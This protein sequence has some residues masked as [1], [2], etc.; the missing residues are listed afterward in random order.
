MKA[1]SPLQSLGIRARVL[2]LAVLPLT[3]V[4]VLLG[5][6]LAS[7]RLD[8]AHKGLLERGEMIARN[9]ALA[10]EFALI[11]HNAALLEETLARVASQP[12]VSWVAV[13][14]HQRET[15]AGH[16]S[17][18]APG[19]ILELVAAV[20]RGEALPQN[21]HAQ[22]IEVA[23]PPLTDFSAEYLPAGPGG[24]GLAN[25]HLGFA[26]VGMDA[27]EMD[28]RRA[29]IIRNSALVTFTGLISSIVLALV[30]GNSIAHPLLGLLA[31]VRALQAG[32]LS[33]RA[34]LSAGGEIGTLVEGVNRM[35]DHLEQ[36]QRDMQLRVEQATQALRH[37]VTEL[38]QRNRELD[39]ARDAA[40]R[41]GRDRTE[42]LA[43]MSHEIRTPLNAILGFA[44]LLTSDDRGGANS[45]HLRTI[46]TAAEQLLHVIDDIL[47]FI[48]L[49]A[50]ADRLEPAWFDL[51]ELI[52]DVVAVL[53]PMA[54]EKGLELVLLL[55]GDLPRWL[56]GDRARLSQ[57]LINLLNNAIKFTPAGQVVVEALHRAGVAGDDQVEV[58]VRDTGIGMDPAE[59]ERLFS[60]FSQADSSISRRFG[61]SGLGLSIAHRLV[62]L[63]GG[64]IGVESRK[65][66]GSRFWV[67]LPCPSNAAAPPA[68]STPELDGRRVLVYDANPL[69]R[70]S[71]RSSL[72]A[73]G[74]EVFNTGKWS[75][76]VVLLR[77][78]T[79]ATAFDTVILGLSASELWPTSL[80]RQVGELREHYAGPVVLLTGSEDWSPPDA[81]RSDAL[82]DWATKPVRR[83][84]L[85][86]L[87][88]D[89]REGQPARVA[90]DAGAGKPGRLRGMRILVAEDNTFNRDLLREILQLQ[91]AGI[92]EAASGGAA[93]AAA[94]RASY[95]VVL[96]D[97]HMPEIDGA[98]AAR[99]IRAALGANTPPIWA[100]TA[101]VFG[102]TDL[103]GSGDCFDDWLLKPID[104]ESLVNRLS[105]LEQQ[106]GARAAG[107]TPHTAAAPDPLPA[108]IRQRYKEELKALI[109][110]LRDVLAGGDRSGARWV[111]H[112]LE[113]IVG[114]FGGA[115]RVEMVRRL[116]RHF[117]SAAAD[118]LRAM[119]DELEDCATREDAGNGKAA[120]RRDD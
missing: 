42:F 108:E 83:S 34:Q 94:M 104:P 77:G 110:S 13:W 101:D 89:R 43:R 41:A 28:T 69:V 2:I 9:L 66:H 48:R 109:G 103:H 79:A 22:P 40:L 112:D 111:L 10:S 23:S 113:G 45:E 84:A 29:A 56:H 71:L 5:Y 31:A 91:G 19:A 54:N 90:E 60:P 102:Q 21:R 55:H 20:Q 12:G 58:T 73:W 76:V 92:D 118:E 70:R 39:E 14:D 72:A 75:Q 6:S 24:S 97:L 74:A 114:L 65:G 119:L 80:A 57:V 85:R 36:S 3:S 4:A 35:A 120:A 8:D 1:R 105:Q 7:S 51:G 100:V 15:L 106:G 63:M 49:D 62:G 11:S 30:I 52:E 99:R 18:P 33:A 46:Q 87:L 47:Q 82:I 27:R 50:G 98:E 59:Q 116:K 17:H 68:R 44:R 117:A 61:G 67:R 78:Q 37:T 95:D 88:G 64:E 107:D 32:R 115:R 25:Q 96:M 93:I 86:R 81:V 38:E 16:G 26:L 53:G